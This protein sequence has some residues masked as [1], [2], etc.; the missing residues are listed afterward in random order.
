MGFVEQ[1]GR[2]TKRELRD[3]GLGMAGF[4]AVLIALGVWRN[5]PHFTPGRAVLMALALGFALLALT[6]PRPLAPFCWLS[7]KLAL[8]INFVMTRVILT[9]FFIL[10]ISPVGLT[11]RLWGRDPL[12]RK[13]DHAASTYWI[14]REAPLPRDHFEHPF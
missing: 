11:M 8:A 6:F 1:M 12:T 3:F 14:S 7:M 4:F 5:G 10:V 13:R 2:Y 9:L